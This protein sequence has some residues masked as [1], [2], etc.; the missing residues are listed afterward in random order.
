MSMFAAGQMVLV[1]CQ[2]NPRNTQ[3]F[4]GWDPQVSGAQFLQQI[5]IFSHYYFL[6]C[7]AYMKSKPYFKFFLFYILVSCNRTVP[8]QQENYFTS[9]N[10]GLVSFPFSTLFPASIFLIVISSVRKQVLPSK[11]LANIQSVQNMA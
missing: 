1:E 6:T 7:F 3:R 10:K 2:Q 5:T 9:T 4:T 11:Q 8:L